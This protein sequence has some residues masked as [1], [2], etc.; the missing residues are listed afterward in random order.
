MIVI[1]TGAVVV[2]AGPS[3]SGKSTWASSTIRAD[4][5][6]STDAL[7]QLV[8]LSERDQRAGTDAFAVLDLVLK[9]RAK[10]GLTTVIDSLGLDA[11]QRA[12]WIDIARQ[13]GR[14]AIAVAFSAPDKDCRS[15]NKAR[16]HPVPS[17]AVTSQL[18]RWPDE[19][20]ALHDEFN[21][22]HHVDTSDGAEPIGVRL[23]PPRLHHHLPLRQT[24]QDDPMTLR[25]GIS[26]SSYDWPGD[27][28][29]TGP[30]LASIAREAEEAGFSSLWVM[31]HMMQIPQVGREWDPMLEST[32]TLGFLAA[33][34]EHI[35]LGTLV[36][37]ITYRNIAHVGKIAA[38]L[39]VLSGGRAVCGLGA[40]W[41]DREHRAYG[42]EFPS[43]AERYELL[44]DALELFPL[45]WGP[46][47]PSYSGRTIEVAE[48]ICY[49][50][51]IQDPIP[52]LVGGS[53]E[54]RTL[55]L[56]ARYA[57]ACNLFGEP[58][59]VRHK[60]DVLHQHCRNEDRD[61]DDIT[62]TQLSSVLCASTVDE[63]NAA[64]GTRSNDQVPSEVSA[65]RLNAGTIDD[66]IGRFR[67]LADAGVHEVIVS[68]ADIGD[69]RAIERFAPVIAAFR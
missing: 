25:F 54:Q 24:Q 22:V 66:H 19:R 40:A 69:R 5:I 50:R 51:P 59:V 65:E 36:T 1:P 53:G 39:D 3:G 58:D 64:L 35:Q 31:D 34:T 8:G 63:L 46:G 13:H 49:P 45:L 67:A 28:V 48:A 38:T 23:I 57:D 18:K 17:K 68:L 12:A 27:S 42:W 21:E 56:V 4:H 47:A 29:R 16:S 26:L 9:R 55:H 2:L 15:R 60:I 41:F 14:P 62:I 20:S 6:V 32:T 33:A 30:R 52:I 61:P 11:K 37:G 7:R 43:I 10:R 44:E